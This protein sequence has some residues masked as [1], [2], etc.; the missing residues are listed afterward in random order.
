MISYCQ[1][2]QYLLHVFAEFEH[3]GQ[4]DCVH[5]FTFQ[6]HELVVILFYDVLVVL[7]WEGL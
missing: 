3:L 6:I 2:G 1:D 5:A 7:V 4:H